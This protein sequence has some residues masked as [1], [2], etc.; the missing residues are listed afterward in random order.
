MESFYIF[1]DTGDV[2]SAGK[3]TFLGSCPTDNIHA[4]SGQMLFIEKYEDTSSSLY[5]EWLF[6]STKI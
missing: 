5:M 6:G 2:M 1:S 3:K 4:R